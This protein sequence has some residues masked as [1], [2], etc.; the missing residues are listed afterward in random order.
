MNR[1]PKLAPFFLVR[2]RYYSGDVKIGIGWVFRP[3]IWEISLAL[4]GRSLCFGLA[5]PEPCDCD[6]CIPF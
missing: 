5:H 4:P 6:H 3:N 1:K 2:P